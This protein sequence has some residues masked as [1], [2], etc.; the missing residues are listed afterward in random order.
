MS[1][2]IIYIKGVIVIGVLV[3]KNKVN[4]GVSDTI[5]GCQ[6]Y[7]RKTRCVWYLED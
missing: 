6:Y 7:H 4:G 5:G 2:L 3:T 1:S